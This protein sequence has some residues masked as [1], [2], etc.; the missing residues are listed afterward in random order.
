MVREKEILVKLLEIL[1]RSDSQKFEQNKTKFRIHNDYTLT[2][3]GWVIKFKWNSDPIRGENPML[4][5]SIDK[6]FSGTLF[7]SL[8]VFK[9]EDD[10][11]DR[12]YDDI[13]TELN[14]LIE[15][16]ETEHKNLR[17]QLGD[18]FLES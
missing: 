1:K 2:H 15:T 9:S 3:N 13:F 8:N 11:E 5:I 7:K 14:R 4:D 18:E 12:I 16:L 6:L 17:Q 10:S